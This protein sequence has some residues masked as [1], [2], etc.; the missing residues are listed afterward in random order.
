MYVSK[1]VQEKNAVGETPYSYLRHKTSFD[2]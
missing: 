1:T 2:G